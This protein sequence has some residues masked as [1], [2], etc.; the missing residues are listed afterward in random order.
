MSWGGI[1]IYLILEDA[2]IFN[3]F[4]MIILDPTS[5]ISKLFNSILELS[6]RKIYL[7]HFYKIWECFTDLLKFDLPLVGARELHSD[8]A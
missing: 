3:H 2:N 5:L 4:F 8:K 1:C 6:F 7:C